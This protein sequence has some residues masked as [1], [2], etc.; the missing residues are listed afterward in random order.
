MCIYK[1]FHIDFECRFLTFFY[2]GPCYKEFFVLEINFTRLSTLCQIIR[3]ILKI[4]FYVPQTKNSV[5][6]FDFLWSGVTLSDNPYLH[7][8]TCN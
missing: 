5:L 7:T 2:S 3:I 1:H 4:V 6:V 8:E